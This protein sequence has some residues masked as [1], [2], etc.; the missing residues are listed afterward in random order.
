MRQVTVNR[1][2][3]YLQSR[4]AFYLM[5][6]HLTPRSIYFTRVRRLPLPPSPLILS[7]FSPSP[8]DLT[9]PLQHGES[10]YNVDGQ[11]GGDAALSVQG[12]QYMRAL[13]SL[14][15]EK[16]GDAPLTVRLPLYL[17]PRSSRSLGKEA[18]VAWGF[19]CTG[20]DLDAE[21]DDPDGEFAAV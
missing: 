10:Q 21:A 4:I 11:I 6:L 5:N 1:I 3:G 16:L 15:K 17:S 7:P 20:V 8:T 13:P 9:P 12:E 19:C 14:I 18:D 2:D